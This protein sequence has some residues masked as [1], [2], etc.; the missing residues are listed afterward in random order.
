[1]KQHNH[2]SNIRYTASG[3]HSDPLRNLKPIPPVQAK[4]QKGKANFG[5][6]RQTVKGLLVVRARFIFTMPSPALT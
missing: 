1:M 6:H 3:V 2:V 5:T 4:A